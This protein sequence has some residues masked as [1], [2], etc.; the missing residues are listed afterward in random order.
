[1]KP[2]LHLIKLSADGSRLAGVTFRI[3]KI[4]DGSRYLEDVYKR[5]EYEVK[6]EDEI[7]HL[8]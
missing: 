6:T 3:A 7:Y 4:E 2:S 1:M 5:Q 8:P